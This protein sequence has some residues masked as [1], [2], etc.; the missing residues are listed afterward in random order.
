MVARGVP[1]KG[2]QPLLTAYEKLRCDEALATRAVHVVLIGSSP[3]LDDLKQQYHQDKNIHFLGYVAN[4]IDCMAAIDVGVLPSSLKESLP[5][6][7]TEYLF[8]G[9][10]AISTDV[11]EVRNMLRPELDVNTPVE[12]MAEKAGILIDF[13]AAKQAADAEQLYEALRRYMLEPALLERH[14]ELAHLAFRKFSMSRCVAAYE[15]LYN[16]GRAVMTKE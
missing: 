2:W 3:F 15:E 14:R 6:S 5:N 4:P 1:E 13:P 16:A 8:A 9:L 11:G 7:I 10:P 12:S